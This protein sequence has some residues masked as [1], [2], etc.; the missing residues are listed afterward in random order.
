MHTGAF[1]FTY[2]SLSCRHANL[3]SKTVT[4]YSNLGMSLKLLFLSKLK[5][6]Y[7]TSAAST[8]VEQGGLRG[9]DD[10]QSPRFT[11]FQI[12]PQTGKTKF[13]AFVV[14]LLE[15]ELSILDRSLF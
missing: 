2:W 3:S 14:S 6:S 10:S 13:G 15:F 12:T 8:F 5:I 1:W 7:Q 11:L 4:Y 9:P